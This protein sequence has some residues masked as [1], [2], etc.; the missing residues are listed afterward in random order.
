[1]GYW[2]KR[3]YNSI[4]LLDQTKVTSFVCY[5]YENW[6]GYQQSASAVMFCDVAFDSSLRILLVKV[7]G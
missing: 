1:M 4:T 7:L 2:Q 5:G 3:Y 6:M